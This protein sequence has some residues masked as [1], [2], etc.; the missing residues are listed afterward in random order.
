[1]IVII[2]YNMGNVGSIRNMLKRIGVK[3]TISSDPEV[4]AH[5]TALILPGVGSFDTGMTSLEE[6]G[7]R[8]LLDQL[9][10]ERNVPVLG[11]CLGMQLLCRSSEEG[12]ISGLGWIEAD[13]VRFRFEHDDRSLKIP[14]M[15]WNS[16]EVTRG[17]SL[18]QGHPDHPRYYFV[19]SYHVVCDRSQNILA[20][21][22]HGYEFVAAVRNKN[23]YG[24]QF[25]PEKSHHSGKQL[26]AEFVNL[27]RC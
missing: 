19:H 16:V 23:I 18:F 20:T 27:L 3:A 5:A 8:Q 15:G 9:V 11:I 17:D 12:D 14:H 25:H 1:M 2:D 26:L 10:L 7:L 4:I 21:A 22:H 13:V 24:T 6:T